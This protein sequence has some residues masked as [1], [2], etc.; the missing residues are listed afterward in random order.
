M[1]GPAMVRQLL[2]DQVSSPLSLEDETPETTAGTTLEEELTAYRDSLVTSYLSY[3]LL[4][5]PDRL[6]WFGCGSIIL[7]WDKRAQFPPLPLPAPDCAAAAGLST[8]TQTPLIPDGDPAHGT[9]NLSNL[10]ESGRA[11]RLPGTG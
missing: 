10:Q 5:G 9:G 3:L 1:G 11:V 8:H 7:L 6:A 2:L 4:S